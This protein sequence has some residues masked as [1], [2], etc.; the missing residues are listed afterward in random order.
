MDNAHNVKLLD[1]MH[2]DIITMR[3]KLRKKDIL[4]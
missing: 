3:D 2:N 4:G 1:K